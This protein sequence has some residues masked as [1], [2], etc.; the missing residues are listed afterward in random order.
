MGGTNNEKIT[1]DGHIVMS[2][3]AVLNLDLTRDASGKYVGNSEAYDIRTMTLEQVRKYD[4]T[5]HLA[6][7][8]SFCPLPA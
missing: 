1:K 4:V 3:N 6:C 7:P 2:H 8:A 5:G